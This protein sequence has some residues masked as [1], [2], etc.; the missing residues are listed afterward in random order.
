VAHQVKFPASYGTQRLIMTFRR[1][2]H[3]LLSWSRRIQFTTSHPVSLKSILISS[4]LYLGLLHGLFLSGFPT[5]CCIHF[6]FLL[7]MLQNLPVLSSLIWVLMCN[8]WGKISSPFWT[9]IYRTDSCGVFISTDAS[10][11]S[12]KFSVVFHSLCR[13]MLG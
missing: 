4:C 7:H 8:V 10:Y 5:K 1:S 6:S 12:L 9:P 13:W 3:R 11:F 2:H